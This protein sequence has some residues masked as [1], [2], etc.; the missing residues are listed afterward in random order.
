MSSYESKTL[1]EIVNDD[2]AV[3]YGSDTVTVEEEK[4]EPVVSLPQKRFA[5]RAMSFRG[6]YCVQRT[7][8]LTPGYQPLTQCSHEQPRRASRDA[9]R[10]RG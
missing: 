5:F 6:T 3:D 8:G 1:E 10:N 9:S 4:S 7:Y 2:E